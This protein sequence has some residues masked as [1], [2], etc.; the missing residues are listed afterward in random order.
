MVVAWHPLGDVALTQ[1]ARRAIKA[2][3]FSMHHPEGTKQS[4]PEVCDLSL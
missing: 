4:Y 2:Q 1:S 3:D